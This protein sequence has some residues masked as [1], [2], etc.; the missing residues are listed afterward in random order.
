MR[1]I[2]GQLGRVGEDLGALKQQV[3]DQQLAIDQIRKDA[4]AAIT[5]GLAEN[6]AV[7]R[8]GLERARDTIGDPLARIST[9]LVAVRAGISQLEGRLKAQPPAQPPASMTDSVPQQ[10]P[11]PRPDP[12]PEPASEPEAEVDPQPEPAPE[13]QPEPAIEQTAPAPDPDILRAAAGI[14]HATIEAHRDT[15]AFLVQVA[16]NEQHFHIPGRVKDDEGFVSVR[17]SGPSLVAAVTSLARVARAADSEVTQAIAHHLH[18]KITNAV[19]AVIATP[20]N[21]GEGTPVRIVIDDRARVDD[22]S[23]QAIDAGGDQDARA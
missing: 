18:G 3:C 7:V 4:N 10:A 23:G 13:P 9:E 5:A 8:D 15:W 12:A 20:T 19:Q 2:I 11:V 22:G 16:G 14:A 1:Q 17:L 21:R 6:R